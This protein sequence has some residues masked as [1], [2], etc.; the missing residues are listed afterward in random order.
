MR[1]RLHLRTSPDRQSRQLE[2]RGLRVGK[3][4]RS[5]AALHL[6]EDLGKT[7]EELFRSFEE[8]WEASALVVTHVTHPLAHEA[9]CVERSNQSLAHPSAKCTRQGTSSRANG[10]M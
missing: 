4:F 7:V 10:H 5:S 6:Q 2:P 8:G 3:S 9:L 1:C